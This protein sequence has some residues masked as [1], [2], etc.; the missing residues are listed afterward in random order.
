MKCPF[1]NSD[2]LTKGGMG[3]SYRNHGKDIVKKQRY[4]CKQCRRTT[5]KP[6]INKEV[7]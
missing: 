1:C 2:K 5:T 4:V 6:I 7:I 3:T